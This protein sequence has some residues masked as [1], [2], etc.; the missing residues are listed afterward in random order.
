M[1][2][3]NQKAI[4]P[5]FFPIKKMKASN[6][7]KKGLEFTPNKSH[8][9][10][11]D[12]PDG[13][14][15]VNTCSSTYELINNQELITPVIEKLEAAY[16]LK[17]KASVHN[18]SRFHVD[19]VIQDHN[20]GTRKKDDIFPRIRL[21][22]SYDGSMKYSYEFGFYRLVCTN[23]LTAPIAGTQHKMKM[24]HTP[25]AGDS[26]ALNKT[27]DAI[28]I[29]VEQ[30]AQIIKGYK[31]LMDK[32]YK[33][34]AQATEKMMEAIKETK[35]PGRQSELAAERLAK[36]VNMGYPLNDWL[37]YNAMNFALFQNES[38]MKEHKRAGMD[39]KVLNYLLNK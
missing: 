34:L 8:F 30:S 21:N 11:A 23:G 38:K 18:Y 12:T 7:V 33:T 39:I 27:L 4:A 9:V 31:P 22:N 29:F 10:V 1:K 16:D 6:F 24:M 36:E 14:Y 25:A 3:E 19:F 32:N 28:D 5:L 26:V 35:Y 20:V 17:I 13:Q 37:V 15:V 2:P